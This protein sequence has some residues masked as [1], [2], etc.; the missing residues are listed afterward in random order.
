MKKTIF[1][2]ALALAAIALLW[3]ISSARA[4]EMAMGYAAQE[5]AAASIDVG[6]IKNV[7]RLTHEQE[8]YWRPVEAALRDLARHQ[9]HS[10]SNGFVHRISARVVSVA[11]N[12]AA[13]ARLAAAARPLVAVLDDEQKRAAGRLAQEMGLSEVVMAAL[14]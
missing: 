6:R 4:G 12:S 14:N 13:I 3:N 10:E 5:P 2:S 8:R 9:E 7:L 11:L 1:A